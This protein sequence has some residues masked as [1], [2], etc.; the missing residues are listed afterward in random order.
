MT[1]TLKGD[2]FNQSYT[3]FLERFQSLVHDLKTVMIGQDHL[4]EGICIALVSSGHVLLEGPPG[5]GKTRMINAVSRGVSLSLKR[6]QCTP[7]LMPQDIVGGSQLIEDQS[8]PHLQL[9]KGPIF[10]HLFFADE[11]NRA[12]PRTQSALLEAMAEGQ[13]SL[14]G[15]THR[16]PQPFIVLA[17]QNPI[18]IEGTYPLPEAQ[19]DRFLFKLKIDHP[20]ADALSQI[21]DL[22]PQDS[23]DSLS[24]HLNQEDLM[25]AQH[26][27][28]SIQVSPSL[29]QHIINLVLLTRPSQEHFDLHLEDGISPRG[30]QSL[31]LAM[32]ARA[33]LKGRL[34]T[35]EDDLTWCIFPSFRHRLRLQWQAK[36][37]GIHP[38]QIIQTLLEKA[39]VS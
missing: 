35:N 18:E 37:Q 15:E 33:F 24:S 38:D 16:L 19:A 3:S 6:L 17:T 13:V 39:E 26:I 31:L 11:L 32:K 22:N 30:A 12:N 29:K 8:G 27:I 23:L 9:V 1:S 28:P 7:D 5:V 2:Q 20:P 25:W 14:E 34:Y 4:I 10:T 21:L 36:A